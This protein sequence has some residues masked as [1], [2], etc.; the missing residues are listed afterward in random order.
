MKNIILLGIVFI[1][2]NASF[3][4]GKIKIIDFD[5]KQP[6]PF[7]TV[8]LDDYNGVYSDE[9]GEI[10]R[11]FLITEKISLTCMGY[12]NLEISVKDILD[13]K[14]FLKQ[15][16][17][18]LNE[19]VLTNKEN[20]FKTKKFDEI[21]HND[22]M[23]GHMLIIGGEI[24]CFI[25]NSFS[26]ENV[27]IRNIRIP[28]VTKTISFSKEDE[29][30]RQLVKKLEFTSKFKLSF[31]NNDNGRPGEPIY[32]QKNIIFNL[33]QEKNVFVVNLIDY[34]I[35]L[36]NNGL[37]VGITN[38]GPV[39]EHD[40]FIQSEPFEMKE[41]NGKKIKIVKPTKPFF[42]VIKEVKRINTFYKFSFDNEGKWESFYKNGKKK[43]AEVH[44][45]G[46]GY[47]LDV[48]E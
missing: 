45:I 8:I 33:S 35:Y 34:D 2:T 22:F 27:Q 10:D 13:N 39:D 38:L 12:D 36:P 32:V 3:S 21:K 14:I 25:D 1:F 46:I 30:K 43:E 19:V 20:K 9:N 6:I 15:N 7:V 26:K 28:V 48:Y 16:T 42:P 31:Y 17:T 44:N 5:S 47:E 29:N 41:I 18:L 24:S 40:K 4:Q 37:F 11:S 23:E